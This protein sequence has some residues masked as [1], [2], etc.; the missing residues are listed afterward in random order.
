MITG[1]HS[2]GDDD[3]IKSL[4]FGFPCLNALFYWLQTATVDDFLAQNQLS[5]LS[6]DEAVIL[7]DILCIL[8]VYGENIQ[9][10]E[11]DWYC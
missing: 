5:Q 6:N 9:P 10:F 11:F 2:Q 3:Y 4:H 8:K 7:R 1:S